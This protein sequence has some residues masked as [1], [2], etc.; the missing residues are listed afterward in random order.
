[1]S[2]ISK[3][4]NSLENMEFSVALA[5]IWQLISRTN[6]YIDETEP[7]IL[8]KDEANKEKLGAVM[9]HLAES[10]RQVGILLQPFLTQTPKK[11]WAQL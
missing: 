4:E 5:S 9:V 6:K 8:A 10:L 7:W 11:I 1:D 2:T 3:V